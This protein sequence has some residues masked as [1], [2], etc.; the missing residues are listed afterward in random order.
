MLHTLKKTNDSHVSLNVELDKADLA[1]AK[2]QAV[3][4]LA[5]SVK[6]AGFRPGKVP[7]DVAEKNLD[8][9]L[10]NQETAELAINTAINDAAVAEELR[11]LDRPHID[12]KEFV[13]EQ[14]LKFTAEIDVL[15][16]IKLGDYKKL[17]IKTEKAEVTD[18]DIDEVIDRMRAGMAE[19]GK[20]DRAA[21]DGDEVTIDFV[22]KK[23]GEAFDGG[24]AQDYQ[25]ALGSNS[26]IPGFEEAIV[27][28]KA[29]DKFDIPLTFPKDY[30]AANLKGAK[31]V[32]EI[33]LKAVN[34]IKL[35]EVND[36]FAEKC[37]PF[38]TVDELKA[39]V[40]RE[41]T[42]QKER[43]AEEQL[44]D[45]LIG[46]LVKISDIPVPEVLVDDQVKSIEQDARQNLMYRG[47]ALEQYIEAQ[48]FK[49]EAD[50]REQEVKPGAV[51]RVQAGLALSELSKLEKVDVTQAELDE[52]LE[53]MKQQ[54]PNM[55]D[56]LDKPEARRD[57]ANRVITEKTLDRLIELNRK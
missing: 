40:K 26:F 8:P 17:K 24:S 12:M 22:G 29:G 11:I 25:L 2:A 18:K 39:D 56:Q 37:G 43:Q 50:W 10:L 54:Y 46:E 15:P 35:P 31:V 38:K 55:T 34:E 7:A 36:A 51:R 6:A 3:K 27:G 47:Q 49:D 20:V 23:D 45:S 53:Q 32:F 5:P 13:P 44:K 16:D 42:S 48:G 9:N 1:L 30:H 19:K 41:L 4:N 52:R 28:H 33:N 21:K 14:S 57:L